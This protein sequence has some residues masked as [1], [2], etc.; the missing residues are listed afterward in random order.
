MN[1]RIA[2]IMR[3]LGEKLPIK[4]KQSPIVNDEDEMTDS[5]SAQLANGMDASID[6]PVEDEATPSEMAEA[7]QDEA[8]AD[9]LSESPEEQEEEDELGIEKPRAGKSLFGKSPNTLKIMIALADAK[10]KQMRR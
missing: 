9:E 10:K 1:S 2:D 6:D 5:R 3:A 4:K 7:E 8:L